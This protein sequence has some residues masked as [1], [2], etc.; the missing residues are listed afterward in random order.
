MSFQTE[1]YE[2]V[3]GV[4]NQQLLD[5]M[6]IQFEIVRKN[7]YINYNIPDDERHKHDFADNQVN[8]S[9]AHYGPFL[10]ETLLLM[11]QPLVEKTIGLNLYPC[12][13]YARIYYNGSEMRIHKDRPSC[14]FSVT[15]CITED[16]ENPWPIYF[17]NRKQQDIPIFTKPG[18]LVIYSGCELEHW[19]EPY[20][21]KEQ[22]QAFLHYVNADGPYADW[23]YDKRSYLGRAPFNQG[24]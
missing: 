9:Y 24:G 3:R 20:Q 13:T 23:K 22:M 2:V 4:L 15:L 1:G 16:D 17:R 11:L 18:D 19:R 10:S 8:N 6:K 7:S 21:G 12:Y 5:Y 14:E